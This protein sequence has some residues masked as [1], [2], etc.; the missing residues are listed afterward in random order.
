MKIL[1]PE[2][3]LPESLERLGRL[4]EVHFDPALH[5][6]RTALVAAARGAD[7]IIVRRLTQV[8][9]DLL[10]AMVR[11]KVVGR[12]GVGLDNIDV[13]ACRA[14]HI[15][16]I[17]AVGAN[18]RSVA[19][20]VVAVAMILVR[21]AFFSTAQVAAG[22]WPKEALNLG[23]EMG[24]LTMGIVGLGSIGRTTADLARR[25]GMKPLPSWRAGS[26]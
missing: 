9:G 18:A 24:G 21:G 15:Q 10:D 12:L 11:C 3:I 25:L 2:G 16:V 22:R 8:R 20:Y 4:H 26:A 19:E 7:A 5:G 13:Q 14:R 6:D 23:R 17:P 1:I